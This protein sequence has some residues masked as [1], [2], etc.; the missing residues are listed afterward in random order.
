MPASFR[1]PQTRVKALQRELKELD[2]TLYNEMRR[3]MRAGI[4]PIADQLH[5]QIPSSPPISGFARRPR[6]VRQSIEQR[7]PF[8]WKRPRPRIAVGTGR[9]GTGRSGTS[10][11][12]IV[13]N[14]RRPAAGFSVLERVGTQG[15][16][17][18]SRAMNTAGYPLRRSGRG[19]GGRFVIPEFY[20]NEDRMVRIARDILQKF[21][22]KVSKDLARRF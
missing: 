10:L 16:N 17:R 3:E 2:K 13:F 20:R 14:D 22:R 1:I 4:K 12:K 11:V 6:G 9:I 8:V 15:S 5:A 7:A 21:G 18:L 19:K